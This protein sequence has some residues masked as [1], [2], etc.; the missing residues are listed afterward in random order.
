M[1]TPLFTD[2]L[3][4]LALPAYLV[5]VAALVALSAQLASTS[6]SA[7]AADG[8]DQGS[9][10][11]QRLAVAPALAVFLFLPQGNLPPFFPLS[12][13]MPMLFALFSL[14][15]LLLG[16][17]A[18]AAR[19]RAMF[20]ALY[21][22][23]PLA[24]ACGSAAFLAHA[25]G[26][27]GSPF[28]MGTFSSMPLWSMVGI[29]ARIG[30]AVMAA[31][32]LLCIGRAFPLVARAAFAWYACRLA[33]AHTFLALLLPPLLIRFAPDL[34]LPLLCLLESGLRWLLAFLLAHRLMPL[35]GRV[36]NTTI[37]PLLFSLGLGLALGTR[38][39]FPVS[40]PEPMILD[41][42]APANMP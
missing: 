39:V 3:P 35:A 22:L 23:L 4:F 19:T 16:A 13:G 7:I 34:S 17:A 30:L 28:N 18:P 25:C 2:S 41:S 9:H 21:G 26:A 12:M 20:A 37:G 40:Y 24:V 38:H 32:L 14:L 15:L 42:A 31:G 27:P 8:A 6:D 36:R 11:W 33:V 10:F 29:P 1:K 5:C